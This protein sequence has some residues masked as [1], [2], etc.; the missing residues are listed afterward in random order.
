MHCAGRRGNH[1]RCAGPRGAL[2]E[3]SRCGQEGRRLHGAKFPAG[4]AGAAVAKGQ[5]QPRV[6]PPSPRPVL[7]CCCL[8]AP[9]SRS[10]RSARGGATAGARARPPSRRV[11]TNEE[12]GWPGWA[13]TPRGAPP[14]SGLV[15]DWGLLELGDGR[16]TARLIPAPS[17]R[18]CEGCPS[19]PRRKRGGPRNLRMRGCREGEGSGGKGRVGIVGF[20]GAR[21]Q[22][23]TAEPAS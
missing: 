17:A 5:G 1:A 6:D 19:V 14:S 20:G 18:E 21:G 13:E 9:V 15:R 8:W 23:Q 11:T 12:Q 2:G 7:A 4:A 16:G 10:R 22:A 3:L